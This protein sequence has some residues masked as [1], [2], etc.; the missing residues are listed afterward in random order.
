MPISAK[1]YTEY[2][3]EISDHIQRANW[4]GLF[5]PCNTSDKEEQKTIAA[6]FSIYDPRNVWKFVDYA[7][8]LPIEK[9]RLN[10]DAV[11]TT[12]FILGKIGQTDTKR[13][14]SILRLFLLH[15]R[16]LRG[17]V[18]ESLSNLWV[19]DTRITRNLLFRTWILRNQDSDDLQEIAVRSSEFLTSRDPNQTTSF[20]FRVSEMGENN[21]NLR[22]ASRAALEI[23]QRYHLKLGRRS[24]RKKPKRKNRS[25]ASIRKRRL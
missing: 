1:R 21:R 25:R 10:R 14:L 18:E 6:I 24:P 17:P 9:R 13:A 3:L 7:S 8:K 12:C 15:D 19:L 2:R 5:N 22:P 4:E 16:M 20:L 11:S 23:I